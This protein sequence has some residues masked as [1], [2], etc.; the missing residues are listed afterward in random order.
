MDNI[1]FNTLNT[2]NIIFI[3]FKTLIAACIRAS[4]WFI[5]LIQP[6]LD[7]LVWLI[8]SMVWAASIIS[9]VLFTKSWRE[10]LSDITLINCCVSK[11]DVVTIIVL[12][13]FKV[14]CCF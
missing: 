7:I 14:N 12:A 1:L 6:F 9:F 13:I 2:V 11:V 3:V 4:C 10:L 8:W 5:L